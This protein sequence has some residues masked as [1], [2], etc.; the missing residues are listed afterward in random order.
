MHDRH[1]PRKTVAAKAL[2][3]NLLIKVQ[4][5]LKETQRIM[6]PPVK[7]TASYSEGLQD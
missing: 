4:A 7:A 5:T 2:I 1:D 3:M 6:K